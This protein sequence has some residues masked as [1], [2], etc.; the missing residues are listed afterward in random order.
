MF[1]LGAVVRLPVSEIPVLKIE[2]ALSECEKGSASLRGALLRSCYAVAADD[3][4]SNELET[5]FVR[6]VGDA[7]GVAVPPPL[8]SGEPEVGGG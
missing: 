5:A 3:G 8:K 2:Q 4:H 6:A 7:V 1:S